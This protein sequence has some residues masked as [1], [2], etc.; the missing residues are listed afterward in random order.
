MRAL[1]A[2]RSD[3]AI[4]HAGDLDLMFG[5]LLHDIGKSRTSRYHPEAK[6]VVFFGH[7]IASTRMARKWMKRM[8]LSTIG[9]DLDK[10][11]NIIEHHM[12]ET[13]AYFTDKAIR[14]FISKV[15]PELIFMLIDLRLADNR[16]GKHPN[17]IKGVLKLRKK[18]KEE[19]DRKPPFGPKDLAIGGH[20][21]MKA[22]IKEGP[23]VGQALAQLVDL[24]LDNPEL[25]T[26]EQL[27]ALVENMSKNADSN[28]GGSG[29]RV[30]TRKESGEAD[31]RRRQAGG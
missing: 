1:D 5:V 17:A 23:M 9:I 29:E 16:G 11:C 10:V 18:V 30:K 31:K 25:N 13:K 3:N 15:G 26:K 24:V 6:R 20:D 2:A 14:R 28:S 7:Q 8:K 22:G 4:Q 19:M 27:L 21:V 12:F